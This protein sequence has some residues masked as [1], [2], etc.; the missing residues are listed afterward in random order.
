VAIFRDHGA[1]ELRTKA[2]LAFLVENWGI[3]K[4]R[5]ELERRVDRPLASAGIDQRAPKH[6]DHIG[7]FSPETGRTKLRR[8][9]PCLWAYDLGADA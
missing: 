6:T 9:W 3:E 7:V 4:F 5:K 1:R 2:R 8:F